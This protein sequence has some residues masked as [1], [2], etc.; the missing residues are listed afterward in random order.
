MRAGRVLAARRPVSSAGP[1]GWEFPGGKVEVGE[2]PEE[3]LRRE[4]REELGCQVSVLGWLAGEEPVGSGGLRLRVAR[5]GV[6]GGEPLPLEHD[7]LLWLS[8]RNL[9]SVD[10]LPADVPFLDQVARLMKE[11]R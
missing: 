3:A 6:S 1:G 5:A 11:D 4:I 7:A 10:W 2:S 9:R 8:E